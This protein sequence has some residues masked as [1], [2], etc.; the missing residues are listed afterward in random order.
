[1]QE[2]NRAAALFLLL[3]FL[4]VSVASTVMVYWYMNTRTMY[5]ERVTEVVQLKKNYF[6]NIYHNFSEANVPDP[7]ALTLKTVEESFDSMQN[8]DFTCDFIIKSENGKTRLFTRKG[9]SHVYS[10]VGKSDRLLTY[11]PVAKALSGKSGTMITKDT[12]GRKVITAYDFIDSERSRLAVVAKIDYSAMHMPKIEA[13]L[14]A[15]F[16]AVVIIAGGG[17]GFYRFSNRN[18]QRLKQVNSE[19]LIMADIM[20]SVDEH[21]A[22]LDTDLRYIAANRKLLNFF[23]ISDAELKAKHL[24]ELLDGEDGKIL[25]EKGVNCLKGHPESFMVWTSKTGISTCSD[26]KL[27]PHKCGDRICGIVLTASD[28]TEEEQARL[29]LLATAHQL[30]QLTSELEERVQAEAAK[31]MQHDR[32]FFEQKKFG[33]M[34]QMM[35]AIAHQWRQPI[36]SVGLYVQLIYDSVKDG[37][38][39]DELLESFKNDSMQLVQHMSKTIDDFRSFFDPRTQE[40]DFEVV[41]AVVETASLVEAQLK[42]NSIAY[43]ISCKCSFR[44]F[45]TCNNLNHPPC[46]TPQTMVRGFTSEFKQVLMNL[47]QNAKDALMSKQGNKE[48]NIVIYSDDEKVT[49]T[50]SD[51]AGGIPNDIFDKIFDPYFTTKPEGKGTGIGLYMSRLIIEEHM[52]GKIIASNSDDGAIFKIMLKKVHPHT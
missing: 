50:I 25:H 21:I 39:N 3:C 1:M 46:E 36:N 18:T 11:E 52:H 24:G 14:S 34:G 10:D 5:M 33:D 4:S 22:Y 48:I 37:T 29:D 9:C 31:R 43:N 8:G 40:S 19:L 42:H 6:Q 13:S 32:I 7:L 28:R 16:I 20:E 47:I 38:V 51:N 45:Q 12:S 41:K 35:N 15:A 26:I 30:K 2:R 49:L 27:T 23:S 44:E 17:L